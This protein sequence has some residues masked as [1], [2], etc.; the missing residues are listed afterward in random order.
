MHRGSCQPQGPQVHKCTPRHAAWKQMV[1]AFYAVSGLDPAVEP[2][3]TCEPNT[4]HPPRASPAA[5]VKSA[6]AAA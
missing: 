2:T 1:A 3:I 6:A 4:Q 5:E